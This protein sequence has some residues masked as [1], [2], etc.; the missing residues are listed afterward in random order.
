RG[1][2]SGFVGNGGINARV[3]GYG[4]RWFD[5][6]RGTALA[7][8]ASGQAAAGTVLAPVFGHAIGWFGWRHTMQIYAA[9]AIVLIIPVAFLIFPQLPRGASNLGGRDEP[10]AGAAVFGLRP[11]TAFA[12]LGLASFLCCVP[13][14][15][16]QG[17]LVGF[18]ND[19]GI[20][21][22]RGSAMLSV[23]LA[24]GFMGRQLRGFVANRIGGFR[25]VLA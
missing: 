3:Y 1:C 16:P 14:A 8:I 18:C 17:D 10:P 20:P 22:A 24:S 5:R 6:R 25:T 21:V 9:L 11:H 2:V 23:M 4:A 13:M 15:M 19:L 7:L 12:L